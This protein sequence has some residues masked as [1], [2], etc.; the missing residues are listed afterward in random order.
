MKKYECVLF[1]LDGTL[2][3]TYQGIFN[4]YKYAA[5]QM[6]L[7]LPTDKLVNEAIGAKLTEVFRDKFGLDDN[8][9]D[10]ATA[11]YRKRY[12]DK[13]IYE[14]FPYP[15]MEDTLRKLKERG[16]KIGVATLKKDEFAKHMLEHLN[17]S[18]YFDVIVGMDTNDKLTKAGIIQKVVSILG[19]KA[20]RTVMVGD[21]FYDALGAEEAGVDFIGVTYGFGFKNAQDVRQYKAIATANMPI[22]ICDII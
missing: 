2:A 3:N 14:A 21:S 9:V 19:Q 8:K 4:S 17:L 1:D 7:P 6:N 15:Q 13:G 18:H 12:A 16:V 11:H 5:E 22:E 20:E 10:E